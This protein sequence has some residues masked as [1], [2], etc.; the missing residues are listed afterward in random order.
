MLHCLH[1]KI[2]GQ[3]SLASSF[4]RFCQAGE[5]GSIRLSVALRLSAAGTL[6]LS[7]FSIAT[8]LTTRSLL[9]DSTYYNLPVA[10]MLILV[11]STSDSDDRL[12][13]IGSY[14]R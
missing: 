2:D 13:R 8:G 5:Y 7:G 1:G 12:I 14:C 9:V 4:A 10:E 11:S 3:K 6:V